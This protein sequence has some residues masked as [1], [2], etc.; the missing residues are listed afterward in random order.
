MNKKQKFVI[1]LFT[2][3]VTIASIYPPIYTLKPDGK[4]ATN[5]GS[6]TSY[7]FKYLFDLYQWEFIKFSHL[8]LE[9]AIAA[10]LAAVLF[11]IL[12]DRK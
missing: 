8:I 12:S 11:A 4:I 10:F 1:L 7:S 9:Y 3:A 6:Y 2:G 5:Y